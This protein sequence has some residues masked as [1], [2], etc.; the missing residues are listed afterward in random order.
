LGSVNAATGR[1]ESLEVD[2]MN[3]IPKFT[4][5]GGLVWLLS[6]LYHTE[7]TVGVAFWCVWIAK[8]IHDLGLEVKKSVCMKI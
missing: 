2:K 4:Q 6:D 8:V 3:A 1:G 7:E 5:K